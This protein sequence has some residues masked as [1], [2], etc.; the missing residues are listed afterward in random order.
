M[1]EYFERFP[2]VEVQQTFYEPPAERTMLRWRESAP[3]GFE[4]RLKAWQLITH[5]MTSS[6]Y[7]RLKRPLSPE[8]RAGVGAFRDSPIVREGWRTTLRC[9]KV[10]QA[11]AVLFQCP[12]SFRPTEE[13]VSRMRAFFHTTEREG[14]AFLWE[15]RGPWP[16]E[17]LRE[18]C[19]DLDLVHVVDPFVNET[20]TPERTY[21]RLHGIGG[22]RHVY[23]DAE[24]RR[25]AELVRGRDDPYVMFNNLPRDGDS[26]RFLR[27][28]ERER[29]ARTGG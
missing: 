25:I 9:A 23:T 4:F 3:P 6:T 27:L 7:R 21:Y 13:N 28:L 11:T 17:L 2:V 29:A 14:L 22:S 8:D 18:L 5:E 20:V 12:A 1:R 15:P 26:E 19:R 24:L 16:E 10:L